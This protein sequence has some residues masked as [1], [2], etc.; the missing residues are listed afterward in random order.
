M[1]RHFFRQLV[2]EADPAALVEHSTIN[3]HVDGMDYLCLHRS[4][5]LTAKLYFIDPARMTKKPGDFLVTPHSHRYAFETVVLA[6]GI[7]HVR[8]NAPAGSGWE[9]FEYRPETRALD[10]QGTRDLCPNVDYHASSYP[11]HNHYWVG[12]NE[13][14]TL[15][16]P[17]RAVLLG[18]V[19]FSDTR[20]TS[21]LFIRT[22]DEGRLEYPISRR[23][24]E[25]EAAEFIC[26]AKYAIH[27]QELK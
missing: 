20:E 4:P 5:K 6:G 27:N 1:N 13:V 10:R 3:H 18:L 24:T 25:A 16:V 22:K 19:Q 15:L 14:H 7:D 26:R 21:D 8:F 2:D 11:N 23:P 9:R 12:A 17:K